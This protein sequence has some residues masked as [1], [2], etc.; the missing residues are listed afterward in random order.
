MKTAIITGGSGA[1]GEAFVEEFAQDYRV[2]F[3]YKTHREK[4]TQLAVRYGAEA[5]KCDITDT[6]D[7]EF[8]INKTNRCDLL[9]NNA[10]I[11]NIGM[12]TD[13]TDERQR[14]IIDVDLTASMRLTKLLMPMM[15][16]QKSGCV[17]NISSVWGVY[18]ASCEVDYSAAKA[19]LI[20]F[21][22]ALAKE[23][24]ASGIR[25]NAI[26]PGV[27]ES[28]MNDHLTD[29]EK[30]ELCLSTPLG[31]LGKPSEVAHAARFLAEAEF[32][33]GQILGVDGGFCG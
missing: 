11:S 16:R 20:G 28:S 19:G 3:T 10:G 12:F 32:I 4:A 22:K 8:L 5:V 13:T 9:I 24:G 25:V 6:S 2:L 31:R 18:G 27:I 7:V 30:L 21:T 1:I 33:T 17:L 29:E 15:I 14:E 26:T 23:L